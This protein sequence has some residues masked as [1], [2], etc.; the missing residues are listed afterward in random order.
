MLKRFPIVIA[1]VRGLNCAGVQRQ[2]SR[3]R[4]R[5]TMGRVRW[6]WAQLGLEPRDRLIALIQPSV[7]AK[8]T[9]RRREPMAKI[10]GELASSNCFRRSAEE[11]K[12]S[13]QRIG[14]EA[15]GN[16]PGYR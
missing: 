3:T 1:K 4:T 12:R 11:E 15:Q 9:M 13:R 7:N 2:L 14:F 8:R 16:K 5:T 10:Q 6:S